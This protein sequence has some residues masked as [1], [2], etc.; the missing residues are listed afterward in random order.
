MWKPQVW[1]L[2][3]LCPKPQWNCT[4]M[5]SASCQ[6]CLRE[7]TNGLV[8]NRNTLYI[9][10]FKTEFLILLSLS[11]LHKRLYFFFLFTAGFVYFYEPQQH[12][13]LLRFKKG[14]WNWTKTVAALTDLLITML[15]LIP[16]YLLIY[17]HWDPLILFVHW[18]SNEIWTKDYRNAVTNALSIYSIPIILHLFPSGPDPFFTTDVIVPLKVG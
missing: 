11:Q 18:G 16:F 6:I 12:L 5:T 15:Q 3:R 1:E 17:Y 10:C 4:F 8:I 13:P 2:S 14:C 7:F 9:F